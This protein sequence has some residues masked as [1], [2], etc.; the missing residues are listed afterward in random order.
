MIFL[1]DVKSPYNNKLLLRRSEEAQRDQSVRPEMVSLLQKSLLN[2]IFLRFATVSKLV[3]KGRETRVPK[4]EMD[5]KATNTYMWPQ[6]MTL[7]LPIPQNT[8]MGAQH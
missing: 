4:I 6:M 1:H 7:C 5:L 2:Q 3:R 8:T